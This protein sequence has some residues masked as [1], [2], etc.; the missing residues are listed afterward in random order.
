MRYFRRLILF[1]LV[2]SLL[3]QGHATVFRVTEE[4]W[5]GWVP[6]KG[7]PWEKAYETEMVVNGQRRIMHL[8]CARYSE[9]VLA[10]LK[11]RLNA[12]GA[13][14]EYTQTDSGF[15]GVARKGEFEVRVLVSASKDVPQQFV[16]LTYPA[17]HGHKDI[18]DPVEPYPHSERL[19]SVA[20]L[21]T[22][23]TYLSLKTFDPPYLVHEFYERVLLA[24]G[25]KGMTPPMA[26]RSHAETMSVFQRNNKVCH[27]QVR[28]TDGV[29]STILILVKKGAL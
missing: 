8:Y 6:V 24:G 7:L 12:V 2:F 16:F 15:S 19:S 4:A 22:G 20:N 27:I 10:Q 21:R 13:R 5:N 9:P 28:Q 11:D 14:M 3:P 25:W 18:A 23:T 17:P 26:E 1:I 29:S